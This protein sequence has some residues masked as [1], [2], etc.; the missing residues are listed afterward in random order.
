MKY[1]EEHNPGCTILDGTWTHEMHKHYTPADVVGDLIVVSLTDPEIYCKIHRIEEL[2]EVPVKN[3]A[4]HNTVDYNLWADITHDMFRQYRDKDFPLNI[5]HKFLA[6]NR[7][8]HAHRTKFV[9]ALKERGFDRY[10]IATLGKNAWPNRKLDHNIYTT[11]ASNTG[12]ADS[13]PATDIGIPNDI[14]TLGDPETWETSFLNIVGET[15]PATGWITEKTFKPII[16]KRPFAILDSPQAMERLR[17]DGFK[18]FGAYWDEDQPTLELVEW[19]CAQPLEH[20]KEMYNDM[21]DI[22]E[23][24]CKH[25]WGEYQHINNSYLTQLQFNS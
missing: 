25:F 14:L 23:W 6:Y 24:N 2:F 15:E 7:K 16:G 17:K 4:S 18:T 9:A 19:L 10:G 20:L 8:P 12:I 22:L 21:Q 11:A 1:T 3:Y 13:D 5:K